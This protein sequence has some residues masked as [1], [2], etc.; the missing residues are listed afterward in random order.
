MKSREQVACKQHRK[1]PEKFL[2]KREQVAKGINEC[3]HGDENSKKLEL[4][5]IVYG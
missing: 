5:E 2:H 4:H 1:S 3:S